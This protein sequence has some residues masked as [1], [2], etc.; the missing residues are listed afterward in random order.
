MGKTKVSIVD[1]N[2]VAVESVAAGDAVVIGGP[3]EVDGKDV[4]TLPLP[5]VTSKSGWVDGNGVVRTERTVVAEKEVEIEV[6]DEP[7]TKSETVESVRER[8]DLAAAAFGGQVGPG[9]TGMM[10]GLPGTE[11]TTEQV[12]S[13]P[14]RPALDVAIE[15]YRN[16]D[17]GVQRFLVRLD[18][19]KLF[20]ADGKDAVVADDESQQALDELVGETLE[21]WEQLGSVLENLA[22]CKVIVKVTNRSRRDAWMRPGAEVSMREDVLKRFSAVYSADVLENLVIKAA[23]ESDVFLA[24]GDRDIGLVPKAYVVKRAKE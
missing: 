23:T 22:T 10:A 15:R 13:K 17:E 19:W 5:L 16:L 18:S 8:I 11:S 2:G 3:A 24:S 7:T 1:E 4:R 14:P 12:S 21:S 6:L 9:K 20:R